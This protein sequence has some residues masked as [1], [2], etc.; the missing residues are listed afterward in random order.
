MI[1]QIISHYRII[2][3]LGG[4][5]MGV[6]YKAEDTR[7]HRFVALKFLPDQTP[8]DH[9]TLE[10][11]EREAQSAS[12]LDHPHI[13]TI[14][15][16][17]EH[18]G[19]PFIAMQFLEGQTL[20]HLINGRPLPLEQLL[21]LGVEITDALDAAHAQGIIHRDIK[22]TNIFVTKRGHAKILD[23][24]LAKLA[25]NIEA[26]G[27]TAGA[28]VT[29]PE[30]LTSPGTAVGTIAY[31]S[32]EQVRGKEL[33]SRTDLFSIGVVLYEMATGAL[34]F[35]GDT[36]GVIFDAILNRE[37]VAPVRLN[38]ELP[39][40]LEE[41]I[42][43]ALEKDRNLRY[44]H[45]SDLRADLQRMKRDFGS[46]NRTPTSSDSASSTILPM[47]SSGPSVSGA[48]A[49]AGAP[50]SSDSAT[51]AS[52]SSK[53]VDVAREHKLGFAV[54]SLIVLLLVAAGG[55]GLYEYLHRFSREPF[56]NYKVTQVTN[57]GMARL[58]AISP[59]GK[60]LLN[61]QS[62]AGQESLWLRNIAT[63]S[64]TEVVHGSGQYF[65]SLAFSPD[66]NHIYFRESI[67]GV[68]DAYNL[69][70][71]P[72]LGG[73]P[74]LVVKDV[75]C[76]STF[77]PD[78]KTIAYCRDNDPEIGKWQLLQANADGSGEKILATG[79]AKESPVSLAWS[80]DGKRIAI[81]YFS[82][83]GD[84]L[85]LIDMFDFSSNLVE[86][87]VRTNEALPFYVAWSP[88]SRWLFV[89]SIGRGQSITEAQVG[90]YSF[91]GA[92]FHTITNDLTVHQSLSVSADGKT[93]ATVQSTSASE[94]DILPGT[95]AGSSTTVPGIP[96]QSP[97]SGFDWTPDGQL[98][99]A[100][101]FRLARMRTDGTDSVTIL[102]DSAG[103]IKDPLSCDEG[104]SIALT[105]LFH[106][107]GNAWKIWRANADGSALAPLVSVGGGGIL[108]NCSP[109][110]K[111]LYYSDL[112]QNPGVRRVSPSDGKSE[113]VPGME[114]PGASPQGVALSPDGK[115]LAVSVHQ[116]VPETKTFTNRIVLLDLGAPGNASTRSIKVDPNLN[117]IVREPGPPSATAFHWTPDGKA[118]AFIVTDKGVDNV[119]VQPLDGSP[120]RQ[121]TN[122]TSQMIFDFRWSRDGK[123][124]AV[125]R[126]HFDADVIL[127]RDAGTL[128]Q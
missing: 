12:A 103:A 67:T 72:V 5:G 64:D 13:C 93:L 117:V 115:T 85:G 54:V 84:S 19:Q 43:K 114:L 60:F 33:D 34:P 23:F 29:A 26:A 125:Q 44:Q 79:P 39:S 45:A 87:F 77:S 31:M 92:E 108:W 126:F 42:C 88:D 96:R 122:F 118:V 56:Q 80:P 30:M 14:Y 95:G 47:V 74:E 6:V 113:I 22:P 110:G 52:G 71:A 119:W 101:T 21:E 76:N 9:A 61:V 46:S 1:G 16:I 106:G 102:E 63:G 109:D 20:K 82:F 116:V 66:G 121:I 81:S 48:G 91:P 32:P 3:K 51:R 73:R 127:L 2:E 90:E 8:R 69:F 59:D 49:S 28:T 7:L 62:D 15:E 120:G 57:T 4:G 99:V 83:R 40:K 124:L 65:D 89:D 112:P 35:R 25:L 11:F 58:T 24:G 111:W 38:S 70:R 105:W 17:G 128:P 68:A 104:R 100:S 107:G 55:F 10:R 75:D 37:P 27:A 86:P 41:I 18:D 98:L 97:L 78:G 94:I 53:V 50:G 123:S 36:S